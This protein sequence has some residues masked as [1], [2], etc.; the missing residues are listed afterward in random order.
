M[1]SIARS[2]SF[3]LVV[4]AVMGLSIISPV[5]A[6]A[7]PT[8]PPPPAA[9][10]TAPAGRPTAEIVDPQSN[11][12]MGVW[13]NIHNRSSKDSITVKNRRSGLHYIIK[14]RES[15]A[16]DREFVTWG[17]EIELTVQI[18]GQEDFDIDIANPT[19]SWPNVTV[20]GDNENFSEWQTKFFVA[21][22][23]RM[24]VQRHDDQNDRKRFFFNI[25]P[26]GAIKEVGS[27]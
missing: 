20:A 12:R 23:S 19:M 1:N 13:A 2:R 24:E 11:G 21:G 26:P 8:P 15:K 16:F 6:H 18:A 4:T 5:V 25:T 22:E 17:D 27:S 14:P 3:G 9:A 7:T 10:T